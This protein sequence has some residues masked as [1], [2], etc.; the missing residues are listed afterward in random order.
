M[1]I[2]DNLQI[3]GAKIDQF[4]QQHHR[5]TSGIQLLAVSKRHPVE[6]IR[7]AYKAGLVAF[8]E[9][10]VQELVDKAEALS[11]LNLQWHFIGPLQSN[12]TKKIAMLAHWVHTIDRLKIAQRLND[13][14]PEELPR[15]NVCIQVNISGELSKSGILP[16]DVLSFAKDVSAQDRLK[17]RGLMVIPSAESDFSKQRMAFAKTAKLFEQLNKQG[18]NL[19]TLSM[20]MRGDMEAAIAEGATIVRIGTAIFGKRES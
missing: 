1:I 5:A 20:G 18:F 10:Y 9:N 19:D 6:A 12:K 7:E 13:Q 2:S 16:E 14:R 3:V 17:L 8:G 4:A 15:L 11:D